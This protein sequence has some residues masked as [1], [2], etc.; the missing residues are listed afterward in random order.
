[1]KL[2]RRVFDRLFSLEEWIGVLLLSLMTLVVVLQVFSRYVL[3]NPLV[4]TEELSRF[5]F[6]WL[7]MLQAGHSLRT[8]G[9]IRIEMFVELMPKPVQT[10]LRVLVDLLGLGTF[11]VLMPY[12]LN[13]AKSQHEILSTGLRLPYSMIY[14]AVWIGGILILL[15]LV[16]NLVEPFEKK[17]EGGE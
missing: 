6:I 14:G 8:K 15:H 10:V 2:F 5:L 17:R 4:W 1:M 11:A 16:E 9:H 3:N 13:Y 12:L 7:I